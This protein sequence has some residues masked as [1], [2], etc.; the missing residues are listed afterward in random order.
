MSQKLKTAFNN[1]W[2]NSTPF[3]AKRLLNAYK[4]EQSKGILLTRGECETIADARFITTISQ[5]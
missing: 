2:N 5:R 3:N 1:Y 4:R